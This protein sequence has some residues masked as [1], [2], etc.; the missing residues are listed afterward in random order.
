MKF[1]AAAL[2]GG[3]IFTSIFPKN[4]TQLGLI[5]AGYTISSDLGL[6]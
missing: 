6:E 2:A 3:T 4:P 5:P 1:G